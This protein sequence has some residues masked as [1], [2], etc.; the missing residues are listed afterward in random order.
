[1]YFLKNM[2]MGFVNGLRVTDFNDEKAVVT[3]PFNYW[4]K[5]PF[6]SIYFAVQSMA[7]ELSS[8]AIA[9][10]TVA[11]AKVPVSMLVLNMKADFRKKARSKIKFIC[12]D[13]QKIR[14]AVAKSV[15]TNEGQTVTVTST[16]FD[17]QGD[18][19]SVFNF[20][21]TFKPKTK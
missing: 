21:W 14:Q 17:K 1:M 7:A 2:P 12:E 6:K 15:E 10:D 19:V 18:I 3:V 8:G 13:G 11:N 20:T 16:G 4:T 9:L 5:N